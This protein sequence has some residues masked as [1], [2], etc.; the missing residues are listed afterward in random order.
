MGTVNH[1]KWNAF[2]TNTY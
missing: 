1:I 2:Q